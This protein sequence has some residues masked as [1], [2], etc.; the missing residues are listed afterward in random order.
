M[1]NVIWNAVRS[2]VPEGMILPWWAMALR[3]ILYPLDTLYWKMSETR[4]YQWQSDTWIIGG[5]TY[6]GDALR[7]LAKAQGE[8]Y[9]ITRSGNVVTLEK[10]SGKSERDYES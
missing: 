5:V 2:R 10:V 9:R 6:S 1:R 8:T 7:M 3:T 4:G